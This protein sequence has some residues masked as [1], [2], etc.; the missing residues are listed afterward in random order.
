MAIQATL[1]A[2]EEII[3]LVS[4]LVV[5]ILIRVTYIH[6]IKWKLVLGD[7]CDKI[8]HVRLKD[9]VSFEAIC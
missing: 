2:E 1:N 9:R 6:V 8:I 3:M 4:S 5:Q 7:L